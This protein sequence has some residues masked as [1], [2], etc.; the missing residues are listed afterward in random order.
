MGNWLTRSVPT[1]WKKVT[2]HYREPFNLF[3]LSMPKL[4]EIFLTVAIVCHRCERLAVLLWK[5]VRDY[6]ALNKWR[7]WKSFQ[8]N[9]IQVRYR[10][11]EAQR[12]KV[13]FM[14]HK[15]LK[16]VKILEQSSDTKQV[17]SKC[18]FFFPVHCIKLRLVCHFLVITTFW[19]HV[20]SIT[21]QTHGK[22]KSICLNKQSITFHDSLL[23]PRYPL[24]AFSPHGHFTGLQIGAKAD[25]D[26]TE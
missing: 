17:K 25:T 4:E 18:R 7:R 16:L 24:N 12:R 6:C 8:R 3:L 9:C 10:I 15:M 22:M 5:C 13:P 1:Q 11:K 23:P 26:W 21:E 20:W 2:S 14:T 19:R